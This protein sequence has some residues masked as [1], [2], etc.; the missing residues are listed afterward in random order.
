MST[1]TDTWMA[2]GYLNLDEMKNQL[3]LLTAKHWAGQGVVR[4]M[5]LG[6]RLGKA[7]GT[8]CVVHITDYGS[9]NWLACDAG[10]KSRRSLSAWHKLLRTE[11]GWD[12]RIVLAVA[13]KD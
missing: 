5:D 6:E 8:A 1:D 7:P 4:I 12:E 3:A 2:N 10:G 13:A 9:D 11:L